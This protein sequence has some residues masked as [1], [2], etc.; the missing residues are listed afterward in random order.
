MRPALVRPPSTTGPPTL[1]CRSASTADVAAP[2]G[3]FT[4]DR[5]GADGVVER[6]TTRAD[7]PGIAL[8]SAGVG[9]TPVLAILVAL[10]AAGSHRRVWWVHGARNRAEHS[11]AEEARRLLETLAN[12]HRLVRYSR[13]A[14]EDLS[15]GTSMRAGALTSPPSRRSVSPKTR[16][17][18][19]AARSRFF[20]TSVRA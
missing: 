7:P 19:S 13:P 9:A 15:D 3:T 1:R 5:S 11:F 18:S 20:A 16:T 10:S 2:R 14:A 6:A 8:I 17:S 4:F 12:G